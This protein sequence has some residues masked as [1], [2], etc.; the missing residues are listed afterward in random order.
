MGYIVS[1][2]YIDKVNNQCDST[3]LMRMPRYR[4]LIPVRILLTLSLLKDM[5]VLRKRHL[6]C[7]ASTIFSILIRTTN[8][9]TNITT[10]K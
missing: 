10:Y 3:L 1:L 2:K 5:V 7:F 8:I 6:F 4:G 9:I